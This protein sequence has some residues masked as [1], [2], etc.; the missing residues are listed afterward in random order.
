MPAPERAPP[1]LGDVARSLEML[2]EPLCDDLHHDFRRIARALAASAPK[3]ECER[4]GDDF[5]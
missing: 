5:G 1:A 2:N 4:V 3:S